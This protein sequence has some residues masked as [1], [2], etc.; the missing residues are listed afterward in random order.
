MKIATLFLIASACASFAGDL[1]LVEFIDMSHPSKDEVG[2][3][4]ANGHHGQVHL[5]T[6]GSERVDQARE[7]GQSVG[8]VADRDY[9]LHKKAADLYPGDPFFQ[10]AFLRFASTP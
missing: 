7:F 2:T 9:R 8:L 1:P 5:R 6:F 3:I 10:R 4:N